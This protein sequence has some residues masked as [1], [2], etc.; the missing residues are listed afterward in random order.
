MKGSPEKILTFLKLSDC[1]FTMEHGQKINS[2]NFSRMKYPIVGDKSRPITV[3]WSKLVILLLACSGSPP[4]TN[5]QLNSANILVLGREA[6]RLINLFLE[7]FS[8]GHCQLIVTLPTL[9]ICFYLEYQTFHV[10]T[11]I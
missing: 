8:I 2:Y 11:R 10:E 5:V 1:M 6:A 7:Y 4:H 3:F 9:E